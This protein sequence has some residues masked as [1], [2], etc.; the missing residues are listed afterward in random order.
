MPALALAEERDV[1]LPVRPLTRRR[2]PNGRVTH[3]ELRP[4]KA[5]A[6]RLPCPYENPGRYNGGPLLR[7]MRVALSAECSRTHEEL[8]ERML[9]AG[10]AYADTVDPQTSLVV[11]NDARSARGKG[12]TARELGVPLLTD[13]EF[14][15]GVRDV[16][17]GGGIV[18]E[19][20]EVSGVPDDGQFALF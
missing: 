10:L 7:G 15:A 18:A 19:P 4:L 20:A 8:V 2:W 14:M 3:E 11:C 1:W 12:L 9:Y 5:L 13:S 17:A 6:S 16:C